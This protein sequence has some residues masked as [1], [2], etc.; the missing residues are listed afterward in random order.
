[1]VFRAV[2]TETEGPLDEQRI[3]LGNADIARGHSEYSRHAHIAGVFETP[4]SPGQRHYWLGKYEVTKAQV[5]A[6]DDRCPERLSLRDRVPASGL[7]WFDAV[8]LAHRYTAWLYENAL[9]QIPTAGGRPGF[10]R[11]PTE[12]EWEFAARGGLAVSDEEFKAARFPMSDAVRR[13]AW[14]DG[15][16]SA[17]GQLHPTG[18]LRPNPLG[19]FDMLG[20]AEEIV[21][22]PFRLHK[23]VRLHG[24]P[25][26]FVTKGGHY[27]TSAARMRSAYRREHAPFDAKTRKA[28]SVQTIGF[29]LVLSATVLPSRKRLQAI[30]E[31]WQ[32]LPR[33]RF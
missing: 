28:A 32:K 26:G 19:L 3:V 20:N 24:Q 5:S 8:S 9:E 22:E 6:L 11:L 31:A 10:L 1:M 27:F 14:H 4:E 21:L 16:E 18:L 29:R 13:Y 23:V 2:Q 25:G 7:N 30:K 12:S 17:A 33:G 15:A